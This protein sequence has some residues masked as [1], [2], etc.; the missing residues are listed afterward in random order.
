MS[1]IFFLVH[2]LIKCSKKLLFSDLRHDHVRH[3]QIH[4]RR[5]IRPECRGQGVVPAADEKKI[6]IFAPFYTKNQHFTK[7]GSGQT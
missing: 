1:I 6:A 4:V 2:A 7:T 3:L 5:D